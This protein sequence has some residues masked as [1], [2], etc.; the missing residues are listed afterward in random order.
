[1]GWPAI[2]QEIRIFRDDYTVA[3]DRE[4]GEV[5]IAGPTLMREYWNR[6]DETRAAFHDGFLTLGDMGYLDGAGRLV[7]V[8]RKQDMI[9]VAGEN[10]YP[11]EV[12][13]VLAKDPA[14][15]LSACVGLPD[16]RRGESVAAAVMALPGQTVDIERLHTL[17]KENLADYK[18]PRVIEVWPELP[19]GPAGKVVR[20]VVRQNWLQR[21]AGIQ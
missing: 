3:P 7:L 4:V 9:I 2:G 15:A 6:P 11:S 8:D 20:R 21:S 19:L 16:E 1:V 10:V 18:R 5:G 14:V 12:E 13:G 17:C